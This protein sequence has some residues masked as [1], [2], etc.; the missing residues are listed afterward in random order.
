MHTIDGF[1]RDIIPAL[2][3]KQQTLVSKRN[4]STGTTVGF[5]IGTR[6]CLIGALNSAGSKAFSVAERKAL[7]GG[8][9]GFEEGSGYGHN[10]HEHDQF[11]MPK[12]G[13]RLAKFYD[14]G[15]AIAKRYA[16]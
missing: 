1:K 10:W 4:G 5:G 11:T 8:F 7:E 2:T 15:A 3:D 9:E 13:S 14:L 6:V 12:R 16:K